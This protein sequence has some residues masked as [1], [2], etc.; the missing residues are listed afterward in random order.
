MRQ[1][2]ETEFD[3]CFFRLGQAALKSFLKHNPGWELYVCDLGLTAAQREELSAIATIEDNGIRERGRW[4]HSIA[5]MA[6]LAKLCA[7]PDTIV[8]HL[9]ADTLTFGSVAPLVAEMQRANI[10]I[11]LLPM[12]SEMS[13]WLFSFAK[14][15]EI[16]EKP[17]AWFSHHCYNFGVALMTASPK[18]VNIYERALEKYMK[19]RGMFRA[20]DQTALVAELLDKGVMIINMPQPYNF[21]PA[22]DVQS[23][24]ALFNPPIL[25][26][27]TEVTILHIPFP[28]SSIFTTGASLYTIGWW[29]QQWLAHYEEEPWPTRE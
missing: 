12:R 11:T 24:L 6:C 23:D 22:A 13:E 17:E 19:H 5:R 2:L 14:T 1:I 26:D 25:A 10:P 8:M 21:S 15:K 18:L 20:V 9:D 4:P 7:L 3:A 29:W 16:Y 28:K 27:G